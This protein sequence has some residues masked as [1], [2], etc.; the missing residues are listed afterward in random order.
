MGNT[1]KFSI[2]SNLFIST[3][4][5]KPE[6]QA[7]GT[8]EGLLKSSEGIIEENIDQVEL[9][10]SKIDYMPA[11][12]HSYIVLK[13]FNSRK[14]RLDYTAGLG[15]RVSYDYTDL[16]ISEVLKTAKAAPRT[17]VKQ[18]LKV[19]EKH[20]NKSNYAADTHNCYTVSQDFIDE[21]TGNDIINLAHEF[22]EVILN[23]LLKNC[24]LENESIMSFYRIKLQNKLSGVFEKAL[25]K[26]KTR[27]DLRVLLKQIKNENEIDLGPFLDFLKIV[28]DPTNKE[29]NKIKTLLLTIHFRGLYQ[30]GLKI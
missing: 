13:T 19:F 14:L 17:S 7:T 20:S 10:T 3:S 9:R 18:A 27:E 30:K 24:A 25:K 12:C 8:P 5:M 29:Y 16:F 22:T 28:I 11:L 4:G 23:K 21:I 15:G 2:L 1:L 6:S 26:G